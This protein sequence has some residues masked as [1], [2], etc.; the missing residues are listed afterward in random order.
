V[1]PPPVMVAACPARH[2]AAAGAAH[3]WRTLPDLA[4]RLTGVV[5]TTYNHFVIVE[6][7]A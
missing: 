7:V 1:P 6:F 4:A 3:A 5:P 2:C